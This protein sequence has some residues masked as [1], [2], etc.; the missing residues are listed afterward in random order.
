MIFTENEKRYLTGHLLGRLATIGPAGAPMNHAVACWVDA[1]TGVVQVGGP[2]LGSS[3]KA[4]NVVADPRVS[5]V[6]DD[7]QDEAV[8]PD[9]QR[10]RG[11]EIRGH[12]EL[13][14]VDQPLFD[15]F[16]SEALRIRP[17]RILSWNVDGP[18]PRNRNV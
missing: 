7:I 3:A 18:G 5:I 15:G 8:G 1:D 4:R 2:A 10:G 13:V 17:R 6:I 14:S 12:A 11:L 9:G 16:S